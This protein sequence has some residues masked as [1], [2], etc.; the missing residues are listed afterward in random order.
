MG[1]GSL[2]NVRKA[3]GLVRDRN[4]AQTG[5]SK[6]DLLGH[7]KRKRKQTSGVSLLQT[8]LD[9]GARMVSSVFLVSLEDEL[10]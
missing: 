7:V 5:L 10:N 4:P 1:D 3:G 8:P 6:E 2:D 9:P